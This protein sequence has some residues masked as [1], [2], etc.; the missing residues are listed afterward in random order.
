M[1]SNSPPE[2]FHIVRFSKMEKVGHI[3]HKARQL[4][5]VCP[6][7]KSRLWAKAEADTDW[8]PLFYREKSIG[9]VLDMDSDF[10]RPV[11]V[12]EVTNTQEEW[13]GPPE[14]AEL[15]EDDKDCEAHGHLI[16]NSM[17]DDVTTQWEL[18]IH[19][20][21]D[22]VGKNFLDKLHGNFNVFVQRAKDHIESRECQLR[23]RE[24]Q[25]CARESVT[26]RLATRLELK[27]HR[28]EEEMARCEE[29]IKEYESLRLELE[30]KDVERK[31]EQERAL[32]VK[33][34][35]LRLRRDELKA[36]KDKFQE[37]LKHMAELGKVQ[38]SRIKLD[39]GGNQFTTSLLT[40][41]KDP[42]SMLAAMFSGRHQLK[43]EGDGSYFI[44]RD[45]THFRYL[46]NYLRDGCIKEGTLPQNE[47]MWR[48][49]RTE[50]EF[51][52]LSGL[53]EYL[54]DLLEKKDSEG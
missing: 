38:E 25:V 9:V 34:E 23:E 7:L 5:Q 40:L 10:T 24:R 22:Q 47:T 3:E 42:D 35:E 8:R 41:T 2:D 1:L 33:E 45:G 11:I 18:D 15:P 54:R 13:L 17:F 20:Q 26:E 12:L 32:A 53:D 52:Q 44:D 21:I 36:E 37:E 46:L 28:L 31:E 6:G 51:Y 50:A 30:R 43:T 49:L 39:I 4:Y 48:E 27:E 19:E 29:K 16:E 14:G